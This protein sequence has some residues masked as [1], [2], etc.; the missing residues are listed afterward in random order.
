MSGEIKPVPTGAES[1]ET[2]QYF[3]Q[4]VQ[5]KLD[6]ASK[7]AGKPAAK[8][9]LSKAQV[10]NRVN[11]DGSFELV[12]ND[13]S[14]DFF[15]GAQVNWKSHE[16]LIR[17]GK[18][19]QAKEAVAKGQLPGKPAGGKRLN[20]AC[21]A[22]E[23]LAGK[24]EMLEVDEKGKEQPALCKDGVGDPR[25]EGASKYDSIKEFE[26]QCKTLFDDYGRRKWNEKGMARYFDLNR[27]R[28]L[29]PYV[30]DG[31][32]SV[33][34]DDRVHN[35]FCEGVVNSNSHTMVM[36]SGGTLEL[37]NEEGDVGNVIGMTDACTMTKGLFGKDELFKGEECKDRTKSERN[38]ESWVSL[39]WH[40][41]LTVSALLGSYRLYRKLSLMPRVAGFFRLPFVRNLGWGA[42]TYVGYD[43]I[44][45][46]FVDKDHWARKYGSPV[47]GGLGLAAPEI[48]RATGLATRLSSIPA[49][50]RVAPIASRATIGLAL[51]WG[52]N[53]AFQWGIGSDYE[54]SVNQRVTD[55]I[56]DKH[57]YKLDGWDI[58][59]LP[60]AVKGMRAG[61]RLLAPDA[62]NWAVAVDNKDLKQ[63]VYDDDK[64]YSEKG[65][66]LMREVMPNF[67]F[68]EK[69]ED[70]EAL[71]AMLRKPTELS[72]ADIPKSVTFF[73]QGA[74]G[75]KK[76]YP[77]MSDDDIELFAR[78][79]LVF[80]IQEVAKN[81]VFIEQPLN[82]WAR[83]VF[84]S[85]G[86]LKG[87]E[88]SLKKIKDRWPYNGPKKASLDSHD[89]ELS[90]SLS[91]YG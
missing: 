27:A 33:L 88:E 89:L 53:K 51:V 61:S 22:T 41:F 91:K 57:V 3:Q 65:E 55:Q 84:N 7:A 10:W 73:S 66:E 29:N 35:F 59:V 58:L 18:I 28:L 56:Y 42:L 24:E 79:A 34:F 30:G 20:D 31:E 15:C 9:D 62:M 50:S 13:E 81:L 21:T 87:D 83:E 36:R 77:E 32:Y 49:V 1:T 48:A 26:K 74:E 44:A 52:M 45:S 63:K 75:L 68:A 38:G 85:D 46:N 80:K 2:F 67:L 37:E 70:R 23:K 54:A 8:F 69:A 72:V 60:L 6:E 64:G 47:A 82:D 39:G 19:S 40:G 5:R 71:L 43:A 16:I 86:T 11:G 76:A 25:L 17:S 78:K 90:Q 4:T 12:Y 14:L